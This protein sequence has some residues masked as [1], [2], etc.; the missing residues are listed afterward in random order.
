MKKLHCKLC[1]A[2]W[3]V[4]EEDEKENKYCPFCAA[5]LWKQ[6]GIVIDS[7]DK[8]LLRV[9]RFAGIEILKNKKMLVA[10][11]FDM[12]P[13]Y[14]K[15]IRI[16]SK[17]CGD[18]LLRMF[19][20]PKSANENQRKQVIGKAKKILLEEEGLQELWVDVIINALVYALEWEKA[21]DISDA[22]ESPIIYE[23][24]VDS[25]QEDVDLREER[26][27][28]EEELPPIVI[29]S[30]NRYDNRKRKKG[31]NNNVK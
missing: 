18:T 13:E 23:T 24:P 8:A 10:F 20:I 14:S 6:D 1:D 4:D 7:F 15:E 29:N 19:C 16:F 17:S 30:Y 11:L 2:V 9:I 5:E 31:W 12:S 22:V 27:A 26:A 28:D 25:I 3:Y 21:E